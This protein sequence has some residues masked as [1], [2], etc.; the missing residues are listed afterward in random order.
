MSTA[1]RDAFHEQAANCAALGSPF[2]ARLMTLLADRL[3]PGT[4][5]TDRL[6]GW[7]GELGPRGDSVPLRLAG[8]L[9]ALKLSGNAGLCA[10]YP[11]FG[12]DDDSLWRAVSLAL[13]TEATAIDRFID[14]PPQTN[15]VRRA[16]VLIALAHW[17]AARVPLPLR[18]RELG[19]S[20]GLN[21]NF[22]RFALCAGGSRFG[23]ARPVLTL[24]P[25]W[26][27]A[28]PPGAAFFVKE[29]A[30]VDLAPIDTRQPA[31]R[32]RLRSYLWPDQPE[33]LALT[34][35]AIAV[36]GRA[37]DKGD[38]VDWLSGR[39][40]SLPGTLL[41]VYT[42]VA[43]QYFP[44]PSKARG[45]A[46]IEAAGEASTTDTPLAWFGM[47]ADADRTGAAL[48]LRLWPGDHRIV[49][50]RADFHGRWVDWQAPGTTALPFA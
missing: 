1:L 36:A 9:H 44:E 38:A 43:W 49:L 14:S 16:A 19:A 15:E 6:F 4:A 25:E 37:P 17:L 18:V 27:G 46:L 11:P 42:T 48:S 32:L 33:R 41:L 24:M 28:I 30:G 29:R 21:L 34:D 47:E 3:T 13:E 45:R 39:L 7:S 2:L 35:A 8:A 20:A 22:D 50:G 12:V 26:R 10:A 5:L 23:A 40:T 31:D